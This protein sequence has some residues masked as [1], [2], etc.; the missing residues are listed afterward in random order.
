MSEQR[1]PTKP[2]RL[3]DILNQLLRDQG[4]ETR[5]RQHRVIAYWEEFVGKEIARRTRAATLECGTLLVVVQNAIW[6]QEL[7]MLKER[8]KD[9]INQ[10]LGSEEVKNI[11]LQIG[12]VQSNEA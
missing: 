4:L 1:E 11:R 12:N 9:Q 7:H 2:H 10:K 8:I 3:A 5:I 6:M